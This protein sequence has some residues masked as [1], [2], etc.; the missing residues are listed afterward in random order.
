MTIN[1]Y[2]AAYFSSASYDDDKLGFTLDQSYKNQ[3]WAKCLCR[4]LPK[5][6]KYN[7]FF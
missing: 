7:N 5:I 6:S 4:N 3:G 2:E 1:K